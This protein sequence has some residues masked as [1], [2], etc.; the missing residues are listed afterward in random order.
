MQWWQVYSGLLPRS[1]GY[2]GM[3]RLQGLYEFER[4]ICY[5]ESAASKLQRRHRLRRLLSVLRLTDLAFAR[6]RGLLVV[7]VIMWLGIALA[8]LIYR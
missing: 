6:I 5:V 4:L 8:R 2:R 3:I 1:L 7:V